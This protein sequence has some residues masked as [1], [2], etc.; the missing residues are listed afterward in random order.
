MTGSNAVWPC[1]EKRVSLVSVQRADSV[2]GTA[3]PFNGQ[4]EAR[5]GCSVHVRVGSEVDGG[6][7]QG[8]QPFTA[9][10]R[11]TIT[12]PSSLGKGQGLGSSCRGRCS[13][14]RPWNETLP[15]VLC[16]SAAHSLQRC[17]P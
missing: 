10:S 14:S 9:H 16:T 6:E 5:G 7:Q 3:A 13:R 2:E 11:G 8:Q 4:S 12:F 17:F 1:T 15:W